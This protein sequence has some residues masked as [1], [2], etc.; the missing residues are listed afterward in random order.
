MGFRVLLIAV[1][2]KEPAAIH[3]EYGVEPTGRYEEIPESPVTGARL[4]SGA[5]LL[6]INDDITPGDSLFARLSQHAS[7]IACH[8]NETVMC[9]FA[10]VWVNGVQQ[11]SV[12]HDA[13]QGGLHLETTGVLPDELKP[14]EERLLAKQRAGHNTDYVFDIPIELFV[15]LGGIRYDQDDASNVSKPWQVL[16]R[17]NDKPRTAN[18]S[19]CRAP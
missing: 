5:Y 19:D 8:A 6:Y 2:G 18:S 16:A 4:G 9:S 15:A 12:F 13:Q 1:T 7:L 11:W 17:T 14:I 3:R 10:A